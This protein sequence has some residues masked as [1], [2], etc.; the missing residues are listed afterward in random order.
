MAVFSMRNKWNG[1]LWI[2]LLHAQTPNWWHTKVVLSVPC[3][4]SCGPESSIYIHER[5]EIVSFRRMGSQLLFLRARPWKWL[6]FRAMVVEA[7]DMLSRCSSIITH[8]P[9]RISAG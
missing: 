3:V 6:S 7:T 4:P 9:V 5:G 8:T 1:D 2:A